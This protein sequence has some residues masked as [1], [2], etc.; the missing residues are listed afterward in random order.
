MDF[1]A[2]IL[3]ILLVLIVGVLF[4]MLAMNAIAVMMDSISEILET[5]YNFV[6]RSD[7]APPPVPTQ[8]PARH[9]P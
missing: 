4:C 1:L 3:L 6:H 9:L 7:D 5:V 8:K 2:V